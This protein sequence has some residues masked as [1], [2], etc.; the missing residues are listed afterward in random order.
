M[1]NDLLEVEVKQESYSQEILYDDK[2]IVAAWKD[3]DNG[4]DID[5]C[6]VK[7][8]SRGWWERKSRYNY[9]INNGILDGKY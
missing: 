1:I 2:S 9:T 8:N 6:L 7:T 5:L 3:D 4:N